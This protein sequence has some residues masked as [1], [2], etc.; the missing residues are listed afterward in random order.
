MEAV[1]RVMRLLA[2]ESKEAASSQGLQG[3][4]EAAK[5]RGMASLLGPPEATP[6]F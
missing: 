5:G 2:L 1:I 4:L 6:S 3:T